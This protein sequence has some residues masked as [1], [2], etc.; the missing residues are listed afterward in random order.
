MNISQ[1]CSAEKNPDGS[2]TLI[3]IHQGSGRDSTNQLTLSGAEASLWEGISRFIELSTESQNSIILGM[4]PSPRSRFLKTLTYLAR[5]GILDIESGFALDGQKPT[6]TP[7]LQKLHLEITHR[8]NFR[9]KACYLGASL[10]PAGPQ[11]KEEGTPQQWIRLIDEA[12]S[13]G[14]Q[15]ATVTG[16]EPFVKKGIFDILAALTRNGIFTDINTNGSS[17]TS[18][19]AKGLSKLLIRSVDITIYGHDVQSVLDYTGSRNGYEKSLIGIRNLVNHGIHLEAKYFATSTTL[20][21]YEKMSDELSRLGVTLKLI[22]HVIH[23]D[24][25][26]GIQPYPQI[27]AKSLRNSSV[28]QKTELPCY[29]SVNALGIEPNGRIRACPKLSVYFGNAFEESLKDIWMRSELLDAFRSFWIEYCKQ[30]GFVRGSTNGLCPAAKVLSFSHGL[31]DFRMMWS[32]WL[33]EGGM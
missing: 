12:A 8:C 24:L 28:D 18:K 17:I 27:Y 22:G 10:K 11:D 9:C 15:H 1:S 16:G 33:E 7:K 4:D 14:C 25:F 3:P 6:Q 19:V 30:E 21:H 2:V 13:L 20:Q 23:G 5:T 26:Q 29:P 32:D 31:N